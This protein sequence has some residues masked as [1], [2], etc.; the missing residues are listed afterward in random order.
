MRLGQ[1]S[2]GLYRR[3]PEKDCRARRK[4]ERA[5]NSDNFDKAIG[6]RVEHSFVSISQA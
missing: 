2:N 6:V 4:I 3:K 5:G 1:Q